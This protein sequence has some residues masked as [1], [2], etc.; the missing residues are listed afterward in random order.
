[1]RM[2]GTSG[3]S[4]GSSFELSALTVGVMGALQ[5]SAPSREVCSTEVAM[6]TAPKVDMMASE[7]KLSPMERDPKEGTS[8]LSGSCWTS[9]G[10][11]SQEQM[12]ATSPQMMCRLRF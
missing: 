9:I 5:V 12:N 8:G 6:L 7:S 10:N 11:G 4:S 3:E 1:M 2:V